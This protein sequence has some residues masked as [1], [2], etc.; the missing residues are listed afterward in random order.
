MRVIGQ[1]H[2]ML[3]EGVMKT[4]TDIHVGS[5]YGRCVLATNRRSWSTRRR[6]DFDRL[7][8][9]TGGCLRIDKQQPFDDKVTSVNELS[10]NDPKS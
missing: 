10:A 5:R 4:Q 3:H 9:R 8:N 7:T 6:D 2:V 1:A